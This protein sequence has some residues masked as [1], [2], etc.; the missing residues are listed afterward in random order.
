MPAKQKPDNYLSEFVSNNTSPQILKP[1][2]QP[3][4]TPPFAVMW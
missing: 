2:K 1:G 4:Y 3:F